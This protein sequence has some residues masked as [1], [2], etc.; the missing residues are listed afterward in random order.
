M[1]NIIL[2]CYTDEPS[3]YGVRPFIGTHQI[4]LA[5]ALTYI[6][7]KYDYITIDDIRY[8]N[9]KL[10]NNSDLINKHNSG[11]SQKLINNVTNNKDIALQL[12][13]DADIIYLV[14]GCF[15]EYEYFSSKPPKSDEV[16]EY[17]K[18]SKAKK[19]LFYVL[20][21]EDFKQGNFKSSK[22]HNIIHDICF[23]NTYRYVLNDFK[24]SNDNLLEPNYNLLEKIS[25]SYPYLIEQI[26]KPIIAEIETG[27]GCNTP[28]CSYCIECKRKI[29]PIYRE[30]SDIICQI[31]ILYKSG[32]RHFRLGRQP[33]FYHYQYK[34]VSKLDELLSGIR[35][36]CPDLKTLHIDNANMVDVATDVGEEFTKLIVKYCTSGNIAPFGIES[37]DQK[38]RN[39]IH[40]TGNTDQILRA[41]EIINKY[42][43]VRDS[44]GFLKLIPGI[45]LIYGLSDNEK[46]THEI[47][48]K[49]LEKIKN[50]NF[51]TGRLFYRKLTN[52]SGITFDLAANNNEEYLKFKN[53]IV[54]NYVLPIQSKVFPKKTILKGFNEVMNYN[55][56]SQMRRY[57]TCSIRVEVVSNKSLLNNKNY[58]VEV[59][60]NIDSKLLS[61]KLI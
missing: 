22:L 45:N 2:D 34:N 29:K 13:N 20:G 16:Y 44:D 39:K 40:I 56:I 48:L 58:N 27:T 54:N 7:E 51:L 49:F 12:I 30:P 11:N 15:V 31:N 6:G 25:H 61:C 24:D 46:E 52:Y 53:E 18:N 10:C 19:I 32:V 28:T 47:N 4:H 36:T 26:G 55:G 1:K 60:D 41:I 8:N 33:N 43:A 42:G 50:N 21:G 35:S 37:F 3:G 9:D 17:L 38:V 23:G 57:D 5:Q 59:I 14:M